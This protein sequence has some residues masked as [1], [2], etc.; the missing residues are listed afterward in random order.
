MVDAVG[1]LLLAGG[2]SQLTDHGIGHVH[3]VTSVIKRHA[4]HI[5]AAV[6]ERQAMSE[7]SGSG[8]D[9]YWGRHEGGTEAEQTLVSEYGGTE[10]GEVLRD[11]LRLHPLE[12]FSVACMGA[13]DGR[14]DV[15]TIHKRL[16]ANYAQDE[17]PPSLERYR[18]V[19]VTSDQDGHTLVHRN[20]ILFRKAPRR[21]KSRRPQQG[22]VKW[23]PLVSVDFAQVLLLCD[24]PLPLLLPP[25]P[26]PL[27]ARVFRSGTFQCPVV[28][29]RFGLAAPTTHAMGIEHC[30]DMI[31]F[32]LIL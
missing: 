5:Y 26:L 2:A 22:Q 7:G 32:S 31:V 15:K 14:M 3:K 8:E 23:E 19:S 18:V 13:H 9:G 28:G 10:M 29:L 4:Q 12:H 6:S 16:A 17:D 30:I 27:H 1:D 20:F 24:S 21:R 25:P 11:A